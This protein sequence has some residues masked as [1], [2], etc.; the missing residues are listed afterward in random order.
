MYLLLS[1]VETVLDF[2]RNDWTYGL[3]LLEWKIKT[4]PT[5]FYSVLK[6]IRNHKIYC[7]LWTKVEEHHTM[8]I[9]GKIWFRTV[10][11]LMWK[12]KTAT[13]GGSEFFM[14]VTLVT[15]WHPVHVQYVTVE[16]WRKMCLKVKDTVKVL[17]MYFWREILT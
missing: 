3:A 9:Q 7:V 14:F 2:E 4:I 16:R 5:W 15:L 17:K 13:S 1:K 12:I 8:E 10:C 11:S 6:N